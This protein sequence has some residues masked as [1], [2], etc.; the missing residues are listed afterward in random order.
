LL[1]QCREYRNLY[2][3]C[4]RWRSIWSLYDSIHRNRS[5]TT[6]KYIYILVCTS[7]TDCSCS[8]SMYPESGSVF[9]RDYL[10]CRR[11][12]MCCRWHMYTLFIILCYFD[13]SSGFGTIST[14]KRRHRNSNKYR[15]CYDNCT[16]HF[17]CN[18]QWKHSTNHLFKQ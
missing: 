8:C 5:G 14:Y 16:I 18:R 13:F 17:S 12:K 2:R 11:P 10:L 15:F 1:H 4:R 3:S 9:L 6:D 7:N